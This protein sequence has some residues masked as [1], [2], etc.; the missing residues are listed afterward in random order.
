MK[1]T[2]D[3][4]HRNINIID[5]RKVNKLYVIV[6]NAVLYDELTSI[7][8]FVNDR[9]FKERIESFFLKDI[10]KITRE[11]ILGV[12]WNMYLTQGFYIKVQEDGTVTK[13]EHDP[14]K[15]YVSYLDISGPCGE[16]TSVYKSTVEC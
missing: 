16:F 13:F 12:N 3:R 15:W 2:L 8:L 11:E 10:S 5:I 7:P 6:V 4:T 9:I 14:K 1:N